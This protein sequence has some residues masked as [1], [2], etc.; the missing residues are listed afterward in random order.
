MLL[1]NLGLISDRKRAKK[2]SWREMLVIPGIMFII[3]IASLALVGQL[4]G[5]PGI[6]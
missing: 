4:P 6:F 1:D 5:I 2:L 3:C